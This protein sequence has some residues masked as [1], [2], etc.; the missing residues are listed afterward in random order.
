VQHSTTGS[1]QQAEAGGAADAPTSGSREPVHPP[2]ALVFALLLG[3]IAAIMIRS[4]ERVPYLPASDDGYYLSFMTTV[5]SDGISAFPGLFQRWNSTPADWVYPPPTRVAFIVVS[6]ALS[7]VLGA[8]ITTLSWLSLLSHLGWTAIN[9]AFARRHMS[10]SFAL[11]LAALCGFSPL[12]LGLGRLALMDSFA[13]LSATLAIWLFLEA[14]EQPA[15]VRWR[16]L[17]GAALSVAILTK[18]LSVLLAPP[19]VAMV[20]LER[21]V[22]KTPLSLVAFAITFGGAALMTGTIFV[23]AAGGLGPLATTTQ[24]VLSSPKT[25]EFARQYCNGPWFRY[26]MDYLMLSPFPTVLGLMAAGSLVDRLR[27]KAWPRPEVL[28]LVLAVGL[29]VQQ[30]PLIKNLRYM[31]VL[32]LSLRFLALAW[33]FRVGKSLGAGSRVLCGVGIVTVLCALDWR[34]FEQFWVEKGGYDPLSIFLLQ[35]RRIIP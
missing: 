32:E 1:A 21:Y 27:T 35:W 26:L 19:L 2:H 7:T 11:A 9:W 22:R 34:T 15:V 25:N 30:A 8:D 14:L 10:E 12:L 13:C 6:A 24:M 33:L 29:L 18:E 28:F 31:T 17:F 3:L 5:A 4:L 23:L 16:V 20:L